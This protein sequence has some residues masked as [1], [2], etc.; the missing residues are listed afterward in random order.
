MSLCLCVSVVNIC[1]ELLN[2]RDTE[3]QSLHS[4]ILMLV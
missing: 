3:T 2:H 4:E 1:Q